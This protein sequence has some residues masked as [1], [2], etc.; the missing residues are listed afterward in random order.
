MI[1]KFLEELGL[2]DKEVKVYLALLEVDGDSV[3]DLSKKTGINRTTIYPVLEGLSLKGLVSEIKVDKKVMYAA[4]SP[5]RLE[6]Y[7]ERRII[8]LEE[9][10]KRLK[11]IIPQ[12]K[13]QIREGGEKPI[14]KYFEGKE[15]ILHANEEF[16]KSAKNELETM[17]MIYPKDEV[18]DLFDSSDINKFKK[19]RKTR[20]IKSQ[21]VFTY[22]KGDYESTDDS[23]RI[24]I[25]WN[26]YP[27][28]AD[29]SI[30]EDKVK[31]STL[32]K[33]FSTILIKSSDVA[34][35]LKSL[36]KYIHD[37]K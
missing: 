16:V 25:D 20:K 14:I 11:D 27:L 2:T 23:K 10:E 13:S 30:Y 36:I 31:I 7:V 4:E 28:S 32:G 8:N 22:K 15:G 5:E 12:L 24:K 1:E 9:Q 34:E 26:K 6:T 19:I 37:H 3:I 18:D 35:T 33:K 29:I 17:Y 21:S